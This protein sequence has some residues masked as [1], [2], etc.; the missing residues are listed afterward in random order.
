MRIAW[1]SAVLVMALSL[2]PVCRAELTG[3]LR[4]DGE[5]NGTVDPGQASRWTLGFRDASGA[6]LS[7]FELEHQKAMHM[8]VVSADLSSFAHVHPALDSATGVFTFDANAAS[9]DP[10]NV[11]AAK[12]ITRPGPHFLFTEVKPSGGELEQVRFTVRATGAVQPAPVTADPMDANGTIEKYFDADGSPAAD[13]A[14]Y[15]VSLNVMAVKHDMVHLTFR[16]E[17][18][19]TASDGQPAPGY[20]GVDDLEPWL[21]MTAHAV[22]IGAA[23]DTVGARAF[24]HLHAGHHGDH[25]KS[26]GDGQSGP[27]VLFML[28]GDDVPADGT[29]RVWFQT[30]H[31]GKILTLPYTLKI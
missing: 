28:H 14:Q 7:G 12:M 18:R 29:Y 17:R 25:G 9:A 2:A 27:E 3:L 30:K 10:D 16:V 15:R 24:R 1:T 13:G 20:V 23:G 26:P 19:A 31:H 5:E 4:V 22:M 6:P 21:G 11:F 8:I